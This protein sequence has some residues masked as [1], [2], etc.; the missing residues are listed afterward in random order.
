MPT[1][2]S[3][4]TS[5]NVDYEKIV[6]DVVLALEERR[7]LDGPAAAPFGPRP[8]HEGPH[9]RIVPLHGPHRMQERVVLDGDALAESLEARGLASAAHVLVCAPTEVKLLA[10]LLLDVPVTFSDGP[11]PHRPAPCGFD[12]PLLAGEPLDRLARALGTDP[13]RVRCELDGA[14]LEMTALVMLAL[15]LRAPG[16]GPVPPDGRA[17]TEPAVPAVPGGPAHVR[18]ILGGEE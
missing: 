16:E 12:N 2:P 5:S 11:A 8:P 7:V 13:G 10:A 14:P 18:R 6:R 3:N 17:A 15:A 9:G 4:A 1:T